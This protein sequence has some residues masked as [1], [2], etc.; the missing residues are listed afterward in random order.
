MKVNTRPERLIIFYL[1]LEASLNLTIKP[2]EQARIIW[3][4]FLKCHFW[5]IS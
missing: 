4:K 5:E 1:P 3:R 2:L